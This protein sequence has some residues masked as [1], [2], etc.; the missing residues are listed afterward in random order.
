MS[1]LEL[2]FKTLRAKQSHHLLRWNYYQ[3]IQPLRWTSQ[4]MYDVF[5][6]DQSDYVLNW[7]A[8]L[9]DAVVN[10]LVLE[11][12]QVSGNEDLSAKLTAV[13][14]VTGLLIDADAVHLETDLVGESFVIAWRDEE[15][16][17][18]AYHNDARNVHCFYESDR[19]R[20]KRFAAKWWNDDDDK[21][22]ITLYYRD[23]LQYFRSLKKSDELGEWNP[24]DWEEIATAENPFETIPVFHFRLGH[25]GQSELDNVLSLQDIVNKTLSDLVVTGEFQSFAQRYAITNAAL[26]GDDLPVS[27]KEL[28]QL[29]ANTD[30]DSEQT[31]IGQFA[32]S[33]MAQFTATM[34]H[35]AMSMAA[36]TNTPRHLFWGQPGD[37]SGEA[38]M[39]LEAPLLKK[40]QRYL[41][42]LKSTWRE[43]GLFLL[44]LEGTSLETETAIMPIFADPRTVQP[45]TLAQVRVNN[46]GAGIPIMTL[47]RDEGWTDGQLDQL[48][49]DRRAEGITG[50]DLLP[51]E[52]TQ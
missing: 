22:R 28:W 52:L 24:K 20:V 9:V 16:G 14:D 7:C 34:E 30:P 32:A 47:L 37:I 38:L 1:D 21:R 26:T 5:G 23:R 50:A 44:E 19:P 35:V 18:E 2:A 29:P 12:F 33:D 11:R 13:L 10:R 48:E 31:K 25:N 17:I 45:L 41:A 51:P 8:C 15:Q 36:I 46:V 40:V 42:R 39:A 43:L 49:K 4:K 3:G 6:T 27:P